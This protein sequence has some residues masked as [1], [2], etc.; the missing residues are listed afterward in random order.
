MRVR[1]LHD[2]EGRVFA[3]EVRNFFRARADVCQVASTIPGVRIVRKPK[4]FCWFRE[5]VFCEFEVDGVTFIGWQLFDDNYW[6]GPE[7]ARWVP[8]IGSFREAFERA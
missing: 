3:F 2:E 1:D 5:D 7:P 8:Q 6:I 4:T